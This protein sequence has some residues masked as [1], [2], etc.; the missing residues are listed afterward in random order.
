MQ[1]LV[2]VAGIDTQ[3]RHGPWDEDIV[4]A[5]V[6]LVANL[7]AQGARVVIIPSTP[8]LRWEPVHDELDEI[9]L[10]DDSEFAAWLEREAQRRG[11][12]TWR[13]GSSPTAR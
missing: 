4:L 2:G 3:A 12:K 5:P 11:I 10:Q 13:T 9:V 8:D 1:R 6:A 7:Q